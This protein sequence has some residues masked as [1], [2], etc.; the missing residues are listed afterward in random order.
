M[1]NGGDGCGICKMRIKRMGT[2]DIG[3]HGYGYGSER[4]MSA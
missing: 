1:D 3:R 4:E 2:D